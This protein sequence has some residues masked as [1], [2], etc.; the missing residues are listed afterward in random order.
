MNDI[1]TTSIILII[2]SIVVILMLGGFVIIFYNEVVAEITVVEGEVVD[3]ECWELSNPFS[4]SYMINLT[5]DN[6]KT[7]PI[8]LCEKQYDFTVN[9][10][11]ILRLKK[12]P[13]DTG[14]IIVQIIKV[15]N[16]E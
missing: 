13:L 7:Y 14:Y 4:T 16:G 8:H 1:N 5:F 11:L 3:T 2:F 12:R 15:P 9:S 6:G 10:S